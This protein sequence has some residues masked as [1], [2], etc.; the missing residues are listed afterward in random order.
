MQTRRLK[1]R[2]GLIGLS[3]LLGS[4]LILSL[5][6]GLAAAGESRPG[7]PAS[8]VVS[9]QAPEAQGETL[10]NYWLILDTA[11]PIEQTLP[12]LQNTLLKLKANG[13]IVTFAP[14]PQASAPGAV[15]GI[16]VVAVAS[17]VDKLRRLPGVLEVTTALPPA[18]DELS[19]LAATGAITGRVTDAGNSLPLT[20]TFV[21]IY[22]AISFAFLSGGSTDASGLYTFTV[23]APYNQVKVQVSAFGYLTEWFNDKNFFSE[24]DAIALSG[25]VE[26]DKNV[27]LTR[28]GSISGI[29]TFEE[30]APASS[31]LVNLV[32]ANDR[33]DFA[34]ST[35]TG[36][37]GQFLLSSLPA[38]TYKMN[39]SGFP[40]IEEWYQD[41]TNFHSATPINVSVGTTVTLTAQL[42][43]GGSITGTIIDGNTAGPA[44]NV[45]VSLIDSAGDQ[46]SLTSS[47]SNG[48]YQFEGLLSGSYKVLFAAR[49][50]PFGST[51]YQKRYY[52]DQ[53]TLAAATPVDVAVGTT[54]SNINATLTPIGQGTITGTV[55]KNGGTPLAGGEFGEL[56]LY[57]PEL[58]SVSSFATFVGGDGATIQYTISG[59]KAGQ[60]KVEF[61]VLGANNFASEFYNDKPDFA[62]A[63]LVTVTAGGTTVNINSDVTLAA[64]APSG[65]ITGKLTSNG[66]PVSGSVHIQAYRLDESIASR[67]TSFIDFVDNGIYEI[68]DLES[69]TYL[70]SFSKFPSAT[71]WYNGK[72]SRGT[73]DQVT[74]TAGGTTANINGTLNDLGACIS[75]KIQNSQGQGIK[76][77]KFELLDGN[78][79]VIYF[80]EGLFGI[81]FVLSGSTDDNGGYVVCGLSAGTYTLQVT[82]EFVGQSAATTVT[83]G[84]TETGVNITVVRQLTLPVIQKH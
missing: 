56:S 66:G 32:Q 84:E 50:I 67:S 2:L 78:N 74:V 53:T 79:N 72:T 38:G 68:S 9:P 71:T 46:I 14:Q 30:G 51:A 60:Y 61:N 19:A 11:Q 76:E 15:P 10:R 12:Y 21:G 80:W 7:Q 52:N 54:V 26:R 17:A 6:V 44:N 35:T 37:N 82:G 43:R 70:V 20:S 40:A 8:A 59:V 57:D 1:A 18:P 23:T 69:G 36:P 65:V 39:F 47:D 29:V 83:A 45:D 75:G 81:S 41:Q 62:A 27:A 25:G 77:A 58:D 16:Q 33:F 55:T 34:G 73:A 4:L 31:I 28:S 24:A 49:P 22:D 13:F 42:T 3:S 64:V 5:M 48:I 63:D